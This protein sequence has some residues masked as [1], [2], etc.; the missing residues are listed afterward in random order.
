[1]YIHAYQ[2]LVWN[3]IASRR[4]QLGHEPL[5]GDLVYVDEAAAEAV[6]QELADDEVIVAEE[7]PDKAPEEEEEA[8]KV[9]EEVT[10][11]EE[12]SRFRKM[13]RPLTAVDIASGKYNLS[14]VV[15]TLPGHDITYPTNECGEWYRERLAR[16]GL[17]SEKLKQKQ[18]AYSLTG[19]YRKL[20]VRPE[21]LTW[22]LIR[23]AT[24]TDNLI[25]SDL[26]EM[27]G[28]P[29]VE[30]VEDGALQS[31]LVQFQLPSSTY[32]TMVLR[33][34]LKED[35]SPAN[36]SKLAQEAAAAA[37]D[38]KVVDGAEEEDD[39]DDE[40]EDAAEATGAEKRKLDNDDDDDD[41]E[42]EVK[43]K[44]SKTKSNE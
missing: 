32:A 43:S 30:S 40:D 26:E 20:I 4:V 7:D 11:E 10:E 13:V 19:A 5:V 3:E 8:A 12:V 33:E 21:H 36:Q 6:N 38:A 34:I 25:R 41:K 18:K 44:K 24:D 31:L 2:S 16:D 17:S 15:L 28:E 9:A 22:Q 27:K 37:A 35:T 39:D 14:D 1:M 42:D 29:A 23:H